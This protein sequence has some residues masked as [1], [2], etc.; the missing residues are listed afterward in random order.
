MRWPGKK[1]RLLH[2][3]GEQRFVEQ[4]VAPRRSRADNVGFGSD[5]VIRAHRL[6]GRFPRKRTCQRIHEYKSQEITMAV[7]YNAALGDNFTTTWTPASQDGTDNPPS[8]PGEIRLGRHGARWQ[9]VKAAALIA[10]F[11]AVAIDGASNASPLTKA[12]ADAGTRV[13]FAQGAVPSGAYG[14]MQIGGYC[15]I[16]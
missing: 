7:N 8:A 16:T 6:S 3:G 1:A 10:Q 14:W 2:L 5:S 15:I 4:V 12:L 11:D 13:G 9:Y